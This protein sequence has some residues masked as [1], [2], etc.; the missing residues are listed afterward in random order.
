MDYGE[1][2]SRLLGI[3]VVACMFV[4]VVLML[5]GFGSM[6]GRSYWGNYY[7]P[8]E[9]V[10]PTPPRGMF[11]WWLGILGALIVFGPIVI[12]FVY[13]T[14]RDRKRRLRH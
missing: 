5:L 4:G 10:T 11:P 1:K 13:V 6:S 14:R 7:W 3:V 8:L 2:V 9:A 12:S